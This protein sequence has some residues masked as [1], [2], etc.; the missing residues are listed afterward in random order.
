[1]TDT[2]MLL[3]NIVFYVLFNFN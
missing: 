3:A 2:V 1:M